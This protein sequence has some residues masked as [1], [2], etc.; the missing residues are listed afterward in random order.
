MGLTYAIGDIHGRHDLLQM[1][2]RRIGEHAEGRR[3]T[4]VFLGDYIDRGPNSAEVVD[5]VRSLQARSER[6]VVCLKGNHEAMLLEVIGRPDLVPW[7]LDNGGDATLDSFGAASTR[8]IPA[9][10][11]DW[12]GSLPTSHEDEQRYYVHA[13]LMPGWRFKDQTEKNKIWIREPFLGMDYDFG[14]HVVHGHTPLPS[15][16]PEV[17]PFRTNLDTGAVFGGA[18]T[19]GIFT[20]EQ[21]GPVGF[22]QAA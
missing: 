3:H 18:L 15:A 17:R 19:A 16:R 10:I 1:L 20:G 22:L 21:G 5:T 8:G 12:L 7:W 6:E 4:L 2:L 13:G 9:D 11:L 14:K